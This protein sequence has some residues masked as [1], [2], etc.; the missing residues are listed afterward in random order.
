[1]L[2]LSMREQH[3]VLIELEQKI[4]TQEQIEGSFA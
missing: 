3:Q 2:P 1:M 4:Q